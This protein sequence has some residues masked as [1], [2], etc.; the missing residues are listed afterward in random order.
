MMVLFGLMGD[1]RK[2]WFKGSVAN[3]SNLQETD[4]VRIGTDLFSKLRSGL[5]IDPNRDFRFGSTS[6]FGPAQILPE[7][8]RV[9]K[10]VQI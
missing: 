2:K 9:Q 4:R 1:D 10:R 7:K 8:E 6:P 5:S 3:G